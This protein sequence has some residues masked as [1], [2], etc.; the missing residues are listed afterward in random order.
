M[1]AI[2]SNSNII[3]RFITDAELR[4]SLEVLERI[5]TEK[6][7]FIKIKVDGQIIKK[8]VFNDGQKEYIFPYGKYSMAPI[9]Y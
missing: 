7:T 8:K 5:E 6:S 2:K 3:V 4:P 9:A 1:N